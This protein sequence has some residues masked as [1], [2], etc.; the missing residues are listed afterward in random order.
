M[1]DVWHLLLH[2]NNRFTENKESTLLLFNQKFCHTTLRSV[3]Q[4][5]HADPSLPC[6]EDTAKTHL[7]C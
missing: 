5:I 2:H 4:S 1:V 7:V 6:S 3:S